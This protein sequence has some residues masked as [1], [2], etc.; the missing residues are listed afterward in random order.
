MNNEKKNIGHQDDRIKDPL[1]TLSGTYIDWGKSKE[2]VWLEMEK[3]ME[4]LQPVRV[5]VMFAPWMKIAMAA[6]FT[7]IIG[8]AVFM[9]LY[10]KTV[11]V[12][13]GQ[14]SISYLPDG[15]SVQLNAQSSISYKP[16]LWVFSRNIRFEGEAFFEVEKGKKFQVISDNGKTDV[17]GTSFNVYSRNNDYKVTCITGNVRVTE[18]K[19]SRAVIL[20]PGE[21]ATLNQQGILMVQSGLNAEEALSW[22]DNKLNF[23][24]VPLRNVFEEIERQY[25]ILIH[26]PE[27]LDSLYTGTFSIKIPVEQ[28][29][30]V[31]CKPFNLSYTLKSKDEY[32]ITRNEQ[33]QYK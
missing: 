30:S 5:R 28:T 25:G 12:P 33:N 14:H 6:V 31:V 20:Y 17:L 27:N 13:A 9:Q 4:P 22:I 23:T 15:S 7:L 11:V 2:Q 8:F 16:L 10:T 26:F 19:N 32:I 1:E 21:K 24:S 29:L 3:K 18:T